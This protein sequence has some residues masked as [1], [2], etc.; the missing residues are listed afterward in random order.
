VQAADSTIRLTYPR[1]PESIRNVTIRNLC[2]G[3]NSID[4]E[5]T[6]NRDSVSVNILRRT[7]NIQ[8]CTVA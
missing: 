2:I 8:V 6:R 5:L 4:L 7:G 3:P 1:L